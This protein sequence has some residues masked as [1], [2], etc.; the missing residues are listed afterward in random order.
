MRFLA[1]IALWAAVLTNPGEAQTE[2]TVLKKDSEVKLA[3]AQN[4]SSK[5]AAAGEKVELRVTED[6]M[7]GNIVAIPKGARV[8]GTVTFGKKN[9]KYGNSKALAVCID[10]IV[11]KDKKIRLTGMQQQKAATN[12]GTATAA[13]IGFGISGLMIYMSQREA[14]IRE[15][16]PITGY[17]VEDEM[18][19]PEPLP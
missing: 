2:G 14:W 7:A 18:F 3:F 15:G 9:E 16:T 12:I 8:I 5:H 13:T 11:V 19:M 10:Y 4:L 17:T 6:V 1:I